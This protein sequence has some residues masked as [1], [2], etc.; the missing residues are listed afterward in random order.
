MVAKSLDALVLL[1]LSLE[2]RAR[3]YAK[4]AEDLCMSASEVHAAVKRCAKAG[5][6]NPLTRKPLRKPMEEYILHGLRYA[7][8]TERGPI[9][10]GVP[11][12]V[13]AKPLAQRFFA[14]GDFPAWPDP[15]AE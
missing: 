2:G 9:T 1:K 12:S 6:V 3:P 7:F 8:P 5:L 15:N 14:G 11:T 13:A 10:R 4:I